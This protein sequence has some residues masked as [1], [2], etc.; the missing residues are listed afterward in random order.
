MIDAKTKLCCVIGN[1][2]EQS[3]SPLV[4]NAAY[5][6]LGLNYVFLA[7]RVTDVKKAL[8][9][10][11][12]MGIA[13]ISVT[14]PH[15]L[16]V[17]KYVDEVDEIAQDIGAANTIVNN[18]GRFVATNT[19]WIGALKALE[20]KTV[21]TNKRVALLGAGGAARAIAFGLAKK[22]S[23]VTV[24]NRNLNNANQLVKDFQLEGAGSL[25]DVAKIQSSDIIINATPLGMMPNINESPISSGCINSRQLVFDIINKPL[26]TKLLQD[27]KN[28][29]ATIIHGYEMLLFGASKQFQLFTGKAAP[30]KIMEN[31]ILQNLL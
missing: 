18:H 1:P 21:L 30:V 29:G 12:A 16:E 24:F 11:K 26:Q 10:L 8:A 20:E 31:A 19:D 2:I 6:A 25:T 4:H 22:K 13:G 17:L 9:G 23:K 7:F 3:I 27:A 14:I 5:K 28:R 15:K